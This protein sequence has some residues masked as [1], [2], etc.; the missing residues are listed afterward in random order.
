LD[1]SNSS[2]KVLISFKHAFEA[3]TTDDLQATK[4][5]IMNGKTE[6]GPF[7]TRRTLPADLKFQYIMSVAREHGMVAFTVKRMWE[8][9]TVINIESNE[10]FMFF[11]RPTLS[12]ALDNPK[13]Y[14]RYGLLINAPYDN[15]TPV[16]QM[17]FKIGLGDSYQVNAEEMCKKLFHEYTKSL[18]KVFIITY[19]P[20]S[21]ST[22]LEFYNSFG[23]IIERMEV[24]EPD[25]P[26]DDKIV[27]DETANT[28]VQTKVSIK[29]RKSTKEAE[30]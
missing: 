25:N 23:E 29:L 18:K 9:P 22:F 26:N 19:D 4:Q 6:D 30:K 14:V 20:I 2:R 28:P 1:I 5:I 11:K 8:F 10:A 15:L 17:D 16:H 21:E 3:D 12:S 27:R 24:I 7:N 13:H